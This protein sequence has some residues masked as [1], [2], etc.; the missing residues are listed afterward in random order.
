MKNLLVSALLVGALAC[1]VV[2][3]TDTQ[4]APAEG[5]VAAPAADQKAP[6]K[7]RHKK[8]AKK[9]THH[10]HHGHSH[11]H[12]HDRGHSHTHAV[13]PSHETAAEQQIDR[14]TEMTNR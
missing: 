2:Y 8:K 10:S 4:V 14:E 11:S 7:K 5:Q 1:P 6:A 3:A 13:K 12:D 9:K